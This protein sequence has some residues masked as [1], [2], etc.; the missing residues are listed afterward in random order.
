MSTLACKTCKGEIDP[1]AVFPGPL[2]L[3]CYAQTQ[4][5]VP[6]PTA[7]EVVAMWGGPV[8]RTR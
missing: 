2:C 6:M 7:E 8:R 4:E 5:D 3:T 1:L